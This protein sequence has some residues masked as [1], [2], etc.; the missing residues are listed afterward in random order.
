MLIIKTEAGE[1]RGASS[2]TIYIIHFSPPAHTG[3]F[4]H[5][6]SVNTQGLY[7]SRGESADD[8]HAGESE[9]RFDLHCNA[10]IQPSCIYLQYQK[11]SCNLLNMYVQCSW[12]L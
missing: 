7:E 9:S 11:T 10:L 3:I 6:E 5:G 8:I 2:F 1:G 4:S 12:Y